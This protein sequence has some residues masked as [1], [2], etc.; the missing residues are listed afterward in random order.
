MSNVSDPNRNGTIYLIRNGVNNMCYIGQTVKDANCRL[1]EHIGDANSNRKKYTIHCAIRKHGKENF[2]L[3]ILETVTA[4]LLNEREEYW[5]SHYDT[6]KSGY[7][8]TKGGGGIRGWHHSEETK[9]K[10]S[11]SQKGRPANPSSTEGVRRYH[12]G[13][14]RSKESRLKQSMTIKEKAARGEFHPRT[15]INQKIADEIRNSK[16]KGIDL[17][18]KYKISISMISAIKTG[19]SWV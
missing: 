9:K 13:K 3:E 8:E 15:K 17:A 10:M 12:L 19:K 7:N 14:K 18:K 2:S 4:D 1:R 11:E 6:Y 5:I 16:M